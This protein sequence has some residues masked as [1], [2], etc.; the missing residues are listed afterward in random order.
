MEAGILLAL[1]AASSAASVNNGSDPYPGAFPPPPDVTPDLEHPG[2]AGRVANIAVLV[3]CDVMVTLL[4]AVRVWVKV[5]ITRNILVEDVTCAIAWACVLLYSAT[6]FLMVK[7]GEGY[8]SWDIS[9]HEYS[10]ML[11]VSGSD[12][13]WS[14]N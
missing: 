1:R 6:V 4:F 10:Q 14:S 9:P 12:H 13:R 11:K 8:H 5:R 3:V 7:Y 2:D